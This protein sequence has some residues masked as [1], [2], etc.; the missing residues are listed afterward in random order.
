[1]QKYQK[2]PLCKSVHRA[3][4]LS[5]NKSKLLQCT[6][7]GLIEDILYGVTQNLDL[8]AVKTKKYFDSVAASIV[9][10]PLP[11]TLITEI[12]GFKSLYYTLREK[13]Q[14]SGLE[15]RNYQDL[16]FDDS[17]EGIVVIDDHLLCQVDP[18]Q[19]LKKIRS[20]MRLGQ[21]IFFFLELSELHREWFST[22]LDVRSMPARFWVDWQCLYKILLASGFGD[23]W[24]AQSE[25]SKIQ[26]LSLVCVSAKAHPVFEQPLVSVII[27]IFN[28]A[29]TFHQLIERVLHKEIQGVEF[30]LILIESNST[31]GTRELVQ[32]YEDIPRI[33]VI[34]QNFPS[35]KGAAVQEGILS[36][37]GSII[38]IQDADLEYDIEDYDVLIDELTSFRS[39]FV[40]GSRHTGDWKM[41]VFD[42]TPLIATFYNLGHIFFV[43]VINFL[44]GSKMKDPF[45]MYKVFYKDCISGLN[46]RYKRFDYDHELVIKLFRRGFIPTEIPVNYI[47]RSFGEGKKVSFIKDGI[48]WLWKDLKLSREKI[49]SPFKF[50]NFLRV[51]Q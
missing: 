6:N 46:F 33:K 31:D 43:V 14:L 22:S 47:A 19:A 5:R 20:R 36:A 50:P 4:V 7:C 27:P 32:A 18:V 10:R 11:M 21:E 15:I 23:I 35:G 45:T 49:I 29:Q 40:L 39:V 38:L 17:I 8:I 24:I 13:S 25:S 30:E 1:M 3:Y 28:E 16:E 9:D 37:R 26:S 2:C 12:G 34:Y 41:R 51:K 42:D 44:I 48:T